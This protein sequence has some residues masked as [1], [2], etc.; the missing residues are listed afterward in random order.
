M[1]KI[2]GHNGP[3]E[4]PVVIE[5]RDALI[6]QYCRHVDG[7]EIYKITEVGRE[8]V[9][10]FQAEGFGGPVSTSSDQ[11]LITWASLKYKHRIMVHVADVETKPHQLN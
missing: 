8:G 9:T 1:G 5:N 6:G 10:A 4:I 7:G 3:A 2:N 11:F